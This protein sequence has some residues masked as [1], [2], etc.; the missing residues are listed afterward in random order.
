MLHLNLLN[1][2][3][4]PALA[5]LRLPNS[6]VIHVPETG[7]I[8]IPSF[9]AGCSSPRQSFISLYRIT[10]RNFEACRNAIILYSAFK[11][12]DMA[13]VDFFANQLARKISFSYGRNIAVDPGQW[14]VASA[15]RMTI[16]RA[17]NYLGRGVADKLGVD[18]LDLQLHSTGVENGNYSKLSADERRR[19]RRTFELHIDGIQTLANRHVLLIDD[20]ITTGATLN[21]TSEALR[22]AF[23]PSF[24]APFTVLNLATRNPQREHEINT[25][26]LLNRPLREIANL[27]NHPDNVITK[28]TTEHLL[29]LG[30]DDLKF[31]ATLL[32]PIGFSKL[33]EAGSRHRTDGHDLPGLTW[34]SA[35]TR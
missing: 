16:Q 5:A 6:D 21:L 9:I 25:T 23:H 29:R 10:D 4:S 7:T 11:C 35:Y 14:A 3:A 26:W 28:Y 22:E 33:L 30:E 17:A 12:G 31:L 24:I 15:P 18:Y 8:N 34:L 27:V 20:C 13:A 19:Q 32:T 1:P 2:L